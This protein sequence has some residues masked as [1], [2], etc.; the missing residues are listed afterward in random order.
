MLVGVHVEDRADRRVEL[1]VH[2]HD[3]LAVREG[4]ER[5]PVRR[6]RPTPVTSQITST[7]SLAAEE[8][9]VVGA[10]PRRLPVIASSSS[11]L[12]VDRDGLEARVAEDARRARSGLRFEIADDAHARDAVD[13]LVREPLA[14]E[15]GAD[16]A[17]ADR[18]A[19]GLAGLEC[20][21]DDDHSTSILRRSS[22]SIASKG[23]Q[24]RV[25]LRDGRDG[26]RP[27]S[28]S[29][30]S[31]V[32]CRPRPRACRTRRRSS[33][34][35][36][37]RPGSGS[38]ARTARARRA[39]GRFPRRA[40]H[41]DARRYVGLSGRRSTMMSRIAPRVQRTSFVSAAGGYW[42]CIPRRVPVYA[43]VARRW[44]ARSSA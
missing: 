13:D 29:R 35:R 37:R 42:K 23:S 26:Q 15:A 11:R 38:R 16:D 44:P 4:L 1:G 9:R 7:C 12:R 34:S 18:P 8:E 24:R 22:G 43:V 14:H 41:R 36:C 32:R 17:D 6:A 28:P 3:V 30:G 2:Q 40:R 20:G 31:S 25:L 19:L 5:R 10:R 33:S 27:A 21:V 39:R